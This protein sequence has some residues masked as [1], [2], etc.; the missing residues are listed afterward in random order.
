MNYLLRDS[1]L[2]M[3]NDDTLHRINVCF[4]HTSRIVFASGPAQLNGLFKNNNDMYRIKVVRTLFFGY[5]EQRRQQS[6]QEY[7]LSQIPA[8]GRCRGSAK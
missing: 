1:G 7:I 6:L 5:K 2:E 4:L 3:F 8:R